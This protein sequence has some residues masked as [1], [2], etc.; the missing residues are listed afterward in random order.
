VSTPQTATTDDFSGPAPGGAPEASASAGLPDLPDPGGAGP[1]GTGS[2]GAGSDGASAEGPGA[3]GPGADGSR[4]PG[5]AGTGRRRRPPTEAHSRKLSQLKDVAAEHFFR[6][7]YA[8]TD[9]RTIAD[10]VGLHVSTLYNYVSGKE[11]LLYLLMCDGMAEIAGGLDEALAGK[12]EPVARL[13]A[14]IKSHVVHHARRRHL[15]WTC[16]VEV[17]ALSDPYRAEILAAR[18]EY[19][20]RIVTLVREAIES[21][22]LQQSDPRIVVYGLLAMGQGVSRW[23]QPD[24]RV[25]A[26]DVAESF[27]NMAMNG[28][29][30]G[31]HRA[32]GAELQT[33]QPA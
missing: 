15:A 29:V 9:L 16:H 23:Y 3:E 31:R 6:R 12:T 18:R 17:R 32:P 14:A 2:D 27:A 33:G 11:E 28:L 19:E 4:G 21:G 5:E 30:S 1:D 24:G 8:A 7:G 10:Q 20:R 26:C 13:R 25:D 22:D